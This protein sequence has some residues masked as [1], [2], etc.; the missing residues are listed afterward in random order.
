MQQWLTII[1][2][3]GALLTL[4]AGVANLS[5]ALITRRNI[6][7]KQSNGNTGN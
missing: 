1:Q 5:T 3:A 6:R 7:R 4:A 2:T